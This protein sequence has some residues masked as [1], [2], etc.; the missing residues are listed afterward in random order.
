[1]A[2]LVQQRPPVLIILLVGVLRMVQIAG[3]GRPVDRRRHGRRRQRWR[4]LGGL[5]IGRELNRLWLG[6]GP[7]GVLLLRLGT[8]RERPR[9]R[10][11]LLRDVERRLF[12]DGRLRRC[13]DVKWG[14]ISS[15]ALRRSSKIFSERETS[16]AESL[17]V[18]I[19]TSD[20]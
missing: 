9:R 7:P 14:R 19:K 15:T 8:L 5:L 3:R 10:F 12:A 17:S 20:I 11:V 13:G 6:P 2:P 16:V 4:L 1:V 18:L